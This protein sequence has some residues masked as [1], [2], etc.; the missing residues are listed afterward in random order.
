MWHFCIL[1]VH[2]FVELPAE[3]LPNLYSHH[4]VMFHWCC[5]CD[6]LPYEIA[7]T[8]FKMWISQLEG[9]LDADITQDK[10][11]EDVKMT[12]E[13]LQTNEKSLSIILDILCS[14]DE[15]ITERVSWLTKAILNQSCP[16]GSTIIVKVLQEKLPVVMQ[17]LFL[18]QEHEV[19]DIHCV[20]LLDLLCCVHRT[21]HIPE[22]ESIS[23][24]LAYHVSNLLSKES[25]SNTELIRVS[26]NYLIC[27]MLQNAKNTDNRVALV[28]LSS[29]GILQMLEELVQMDDKQL[30]HTPN[31]VT[32]QACALSLLAQLIDVQRK[33]NVKVQYQITM[34][35]TSALN[36][37]QKA[38]QN[39]SR[40]CGTKVLTSLLTANFQ[41][42]VLKLNEERDGTVLLSDADVGLDISSCQLR[43]LLIILQNNMLKGDDILCLA[44]VHCL[45]AL[46]LYTN[47]KNKDLGKHLLNQPWNQLL[48]SQCLDLCETDGMLVCVLNLINLFVKFDSDGTVVTQAMVD[49]VL[50]HVVKYEQTSHRHI[51]QVSFQYIELI[52]QILELNS[53]RISIRL[54]EKV[55]QQMATYMDYPQSID[56]H[57]LSAILSIQGVILPS[58]SPC[59][60][61][62]DAKTAAC[63]IHT[64]LKS[65]M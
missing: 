2:R 10:S 65:L 16:T 41:S 44:S 29:S 23:A 40:V 15:D 12:L 31:M 42:P 58:E 11:S 27:L 50:E 19:K 6:T 46:M 60:L 53:L 48:L 37:I 64:K 9:H 32:L 4:P 18:R 7:K 56:N 14:G 17:K 51:S 47:Q 45:H 57:A 24:K 55:A 43:K 21:C 36:T 52:K 34:D 26:L 22:M 3:D 5:T 39:I 62:Q 1:I 61:I 63:K 38:R 13:L 49:T 54:R 35:L 59:G 20:A 8:L 33:T 30:I 28:I 25:T